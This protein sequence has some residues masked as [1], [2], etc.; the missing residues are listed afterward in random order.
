MTNKI[1]GGAEKTF[2]VTPVYQII[3]VEQTSSTGNNLNGTTINMVKMS[4]NSGYHAQITLKVVSP[5]G[6]KVTVSGTGLKINGDELSQHCLILP[7]IHWMQL[8]MR[9]LAGH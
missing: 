4:G 3:S 8:I 5:G 1:T 9:L 2:T 6:S 7:A